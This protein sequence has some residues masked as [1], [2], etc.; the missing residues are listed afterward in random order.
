MKVLLLISLFLT[1]C[2]FLTIENLK[3]QID[4]GCPKTCFPE[5]WNGL[6]KIETDSVS[7]DCRSK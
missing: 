7:C 4:K 5:K 1:G 6:V 2:N 3:T